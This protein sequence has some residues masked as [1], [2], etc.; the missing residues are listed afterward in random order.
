MLREYG[1]GLGA[2]PWLRCR[3]P[4]ICVFYGVVIRMYG[5]DHAPPH[6]HAIYGDDEA[7]IGI[8]SLEVIR[9]A[10]PARALALTLE[11][12]LLHREDL[13]EDWNLCV[14][15]QTPRKIPPLP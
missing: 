2:H 13:L 15:N 11:W 3:M 6:F 5:G 12:A 8:R 1:D 10:L 4:T 14:M 7:V 9:G